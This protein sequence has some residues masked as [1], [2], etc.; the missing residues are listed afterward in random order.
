MQP[1]VVNASVN[2]PSADLYRYLLDIASRPE[3]ADC[4][5][6][7]FR[8]TRVASSGVGASARFQFGGLR[9]DRWADSAIVELEE[10]QLIRELGS[11]GRNCRVPLVIEYRLSDRGHAM[12]GI[13]MTIWTEPSKRIDHIR[14]IG[15]RGWTKRNAAKALRRLG[16]ILEDVPR[17]S[18]GKRPTV[19]GLDPHYVPNP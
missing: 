9:R 10:N 1:V 16:D 18:L 2:R 6:D 4:L 12:T 15:Q 14:E 5:F 19:A 17:A 7:N 13:E 11:T 3:F 8:L